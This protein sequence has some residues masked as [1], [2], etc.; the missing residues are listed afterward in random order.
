MFFMLLSVTWKLLGDK[1]TTRQQRKLKAYE[2]A[3]ALGS[4]KS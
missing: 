2:A 3:T 4:L 1:T